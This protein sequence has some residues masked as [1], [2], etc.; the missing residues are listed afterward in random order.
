VC[1]PTGATFV[2]A[3]QARRDTGAAFV[4]VVNQVRSGT[5]WAMSY[6]LGGEG[7]RTVIVPLVWRQRDGWRNQNGWSSS[8]AIQSTTGQP[9]GVTVSYF[10]AQGG[11]SVQS[12]AYTVPGHST[13]IINPA[14]PGSGSFEGSAVVTA[15]QQ[16]VVMVNYSATGTT[17]DAAMS[18]LG[19]NR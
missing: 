13:I 7:S 11:P 16:V 6:E 4:G 14:P 15:T 12:D 17:D 9:A 19:V 5:N 10:P 2:G 1:V 3:G 18:I 8:L